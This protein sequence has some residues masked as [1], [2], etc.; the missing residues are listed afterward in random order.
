MPRPGPPAVSIST[1]RETPSALGLAQATAGGRIGSLARLGAGCTVGAGALVLSGSFAGQRPAMAPVVSS[2]SL[3]LAAATLAGP[4]S[5]WLAPNPIA[6]TAR[7]T[8]PPAARTETLR[9]TNSRRELPPGKNVRRKWLS[10]G[11]GFDF[12]CA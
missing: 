8:P 12:N 7:T 5:Q 4:D 11:C 1:V 9:I 3:L 10:A 6:A 2:A